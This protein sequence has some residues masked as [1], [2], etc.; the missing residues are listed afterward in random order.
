MQPLSRNVTVTGYCG[1]HL[2]RTRFS[3]DSSARNNF[4]FIASELLNNNAKF[5]MDYSL[6]LPDTELGELEF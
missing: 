5:C 6:H 3:P 1:H 4:I 2:L